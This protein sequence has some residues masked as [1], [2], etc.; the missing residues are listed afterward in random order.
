MYAGVLDK[1]GAEREWDAF[2]Y[3]KDA[4]AGHMEQAWN[5]KVLEKHNVFNKHR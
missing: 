3:G 4:T 5:Q 1:A 2:M